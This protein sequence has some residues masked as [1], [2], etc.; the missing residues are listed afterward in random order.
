M[1][2]D[3]QRQKHREN[4]LSSL[5]MAIETLNLVKEV[6]SIMPAKTFFGSAGIILTMIRVDLSLLRLIGYKLMER[7]QDSMTNEKDCVELGLACTGVCIALNR[8]LDGRSLKDLNNSVCV[9]FEQL[10]T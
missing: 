9:A 5:N 7:A 8:G 2:P 10:M 4:V 1:G 6:S 3:A